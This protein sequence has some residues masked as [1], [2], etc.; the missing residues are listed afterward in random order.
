MYDKDL[1][2]FSYSFPLEKCIRAP[3]SPEPRVLSPN[4]L[5]NSYSK[6]ALR[7]EDET[8]KCDENKAF[9]P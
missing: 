9:M 7:S 5:A 4:S 1:K 3:H 6:E 8:L 2:T